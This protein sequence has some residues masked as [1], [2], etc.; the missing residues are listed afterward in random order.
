[1]LQSVIGEGT[2]CANPYSRYDSLLD[3]IRVFF[4]EKTKVDQIIEN[5][6][7]SGTAVVVEHKENPADSG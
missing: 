5:F 1:L 2:G 3:P 7:S 6:G 4:S